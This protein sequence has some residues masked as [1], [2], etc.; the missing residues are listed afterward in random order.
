M[1]QFEEKACLPG[2]QTVS[3]V[4]RGSFG[5]VYQIERQIGE[6][7]EKA[8]LKVISIPQDNSDIEELYNEGYDNESIKVAIE[9]HL[10][11]VLSEY[12]MMSRM[13]ACQNIVHCEDIIR[14]KH[15]DDIG[16][17]ILIRME[18][19]TPLTKSL[20]VDISDETV[21]KVATDICKALIECSKHKVIH[22]DIKPQ[23]IF[24]SENGEYKLG[25]FGIAKTIEKTMG[26]T[27][28]GTY[29]YM[30]PE[31]YKSE[32]Y[33]HSA[34][35]YSLGLVLYWMLNDKRM[36]FMPPA[37]EKITANM[38]SRSR[39]RRLKGEPLPEPV[40]GSAELKKI[41]LKACSYDVMDR[42]KTAAEMLQ[43][44]KDTFTPPPP[45][46]PPPPPNDP[47]GDKKKK[48]SKKEKKPKEKKSSNGK[49]PKKLIVAL[50]VAVAVFFVLLVSS[51]L[52]IFFN[53]GN[54]GIRA[55]IEDTY[56]IYLIERHLSENKLDEAF[57]LYE[58]LNDSENATDTYCDICLAYAKNCY[59]VQN[60]A[61]SM[62]WLLKIDKSYKD[63]E[64]A[65]IFMMDVTYEYAKQ[66]YNVGDYCDAEALLSTIPSTY[67]HYDDVQALMNNAKYNH[68][69]AY[70][71]KYNDLTFKYLNDLIKL[72]YKDAQQLYDELYKWE[73]KVVFNNSYFD[74]VTNRSILKIDDPC[75]YHILVNGGPPNGKISLMATEYTPAREET[76]DLGYLFANDEYIDKL[77]V[78]GAGR[79][80]IKVYDDKGNFLAENSVTLY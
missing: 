62:D 29:K 70:Y 44:I 61:D 6:Y 52:I 67:E 41:V 76:H 46:P 48:K 58:E 38:D 18:L 63:F 65:K 21:I 77:L 16:W 59:A 19:L 27:K 40:H 32:K 35:I 30:A 36:P 45:P 64:A 37:P 20:S 49:S 34:D 25:D 60:Y 68:I 74:D 12:E 26:G 80:K 15:T 78:V 33:G 13:S 56:N 57:E 17:D 3:L 5:T 14:R 23:N 8:A 42:Y 10:N 66:Y 31:V 39:E 24:V 51:G 7:T 55:K 22:R 73:V 4:G 11:S 72:H 71:T 1:S 43:D 69:K 28:I 54:N 53:V 79:Y 75:Y 47:I 9:H 50:V 2:W